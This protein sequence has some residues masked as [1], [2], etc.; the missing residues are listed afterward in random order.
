MTELTTY[1]SLRY[2]MITENLPCYWKALLAKDG[3]PRVFGEHADRRRWMDETDA[4]RHFTTVWASHLE[5][6]TRVAPRIAQPDAHVM[7]EGKQRDFAPPGY[8]YRHLSICGAA[9]IAR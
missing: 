7:L 5:P 8:Q 4:L 6:A 2:F 9:F 3:D 1:E